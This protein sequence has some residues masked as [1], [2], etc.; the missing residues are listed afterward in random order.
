MYTL[1]GGGGWG[2]GVGGVRSVVNCLLLMKSLN[3]TETL[4]LLSRMFSLILKAICRFGFYFTECNIIY[5]A[6]DLSD[7]YELLAN[8]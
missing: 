2:R 4:H 8:A 6:V 1:E 3:K 5:D 7:L